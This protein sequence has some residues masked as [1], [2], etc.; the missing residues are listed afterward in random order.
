MLLVEQSL[1]PRAKSCCIFQYTEKQYCI[2]GHG[3][4][5]FKVVLNV[6][7]QKGSF[8]TDLFPKR[9]MYKI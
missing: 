7:F 5:S 4:E 6:T 3:N 1:F 9:E 2:Q 8:C